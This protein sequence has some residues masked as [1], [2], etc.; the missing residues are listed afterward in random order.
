MDDPY[1]IVGDANS[2]IQLHAAA[3]DWAVTQKYAVYEG[4]QEI[5]VVQ[6]EP[7]IPDKPKVIDPADLV[8]D[9]EAHQTPDDGFPPSGDGSLAP[10]QEVPKRPYGNQPK[11]MWITYATAVDPDLTAERAEGM[12]KADLMSRY[13][14]RL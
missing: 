8:S 4:A 2:V 12:S 6:R 7:L 3:A 13:G 9:P 10:K 14:E 5:P 1:V 11:S